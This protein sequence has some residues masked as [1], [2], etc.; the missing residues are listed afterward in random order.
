LQGSTTSFPTTLRRCGLRVA[1]QF[2][3]TLQAD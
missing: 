2:S 3:V 1:S